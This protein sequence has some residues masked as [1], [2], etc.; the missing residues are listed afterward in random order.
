LHDLVAEA[1]HF[2]PLAGTPPR[3]LVLGREVQLGNGYADLVAREY[4]PRN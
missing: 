1:P 2:L 4:Y 3:L